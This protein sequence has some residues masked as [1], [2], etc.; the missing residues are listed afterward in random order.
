MVTDFSSRRRSI[1]EQF[2]VKYKEYQGV[3]EYLVASKLDFDVLKVPLYAKTFNENGGLITNKPETKWKNMP[4]SYALIR[5]DDGE[6]FTTNGKAV[7]DVYSV[8]QNRDMF[9][10]L[11]QICDLGHIQLDTAGSFNSGRKVFVTIDLKDN[12]EIFNNDVIERRL[13]I[14][15]R[16]DGKGSI[17]IRF[18]NTRVVCQNTLE[19]ALREDTK[20]AWGI[21]H[22]LNKDDRLD[23]VREILSGM[24]S[25][26]AQVEEKLRYYKQVELSDKQELQ[27]LALAYFP[28][29]TY[30]KLKENNFVLTE[31]IL[32]DTTKTKDQNMLKEF[33]K[34]RAT[35]EQGIGQEMHKNTV[36][37][38]YNGITCYIQNVKDYSSGEDHFNNIQSDNTLVKFENKLLENL[39]EVSKV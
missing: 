29:K 33:N 4:L 14:S 24:K 9:G 15:N 21:R 1:F 13:L 5:S 10:F 22:T 11:N 6:M 19:L 2:G 8:F 7:T 30:I 17:N 12:I 28:D 35:M 38:V 36:L 31:E 26:K 39:I 16:H 32:E 23:T 34:L 18:I 3:D 25:Q 27:L 20:F 37:H